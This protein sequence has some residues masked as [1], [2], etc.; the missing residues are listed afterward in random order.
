MSYETWFLE[1]VERSKH[2]G[3]T[4]PSVS[5]T[6]P[7]V[8]RN[9][10]TLKAIHDLMVGYLG[11]PP[12]PRIL[13]G[14]C[15]A[16][17]MNLQDPLER[18]LGT[19]AFFTLGYVKIGDRLFHEFSENDVINWMKDG[20]PDLREFKGHAWLTLPSMEIIDFTFT[21]TATSVWN[22]E[23]GEVCVGAV[24]NHPSNLK[25]MEYHPVIVGDDTIFGIGAGL[26][27][28]PVH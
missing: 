22:R 6:Q 26:M 9:E 25:D 17:H 12:D 16:T 27:L 15:L 2:L 11:D 19:S 13:I 4:P 7:P 28:Y 20:I 10:N 21:A 3:F 1:A 5:T 8:L 23:T 18:I 14:N 24:A